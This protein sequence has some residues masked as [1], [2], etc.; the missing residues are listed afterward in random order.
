MYNVS[1]MSGHTTDSKPC[2]WHS[3]TYS[4]K[5]VHDYDP[6]MHHVIFHVN[7]MKNLLTF[8]MIKGPSRIYQTLMT[9][10]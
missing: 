2:E 4:H 3:T 7:H 5:F 8:D 1:M 10:S 6:T 9:S